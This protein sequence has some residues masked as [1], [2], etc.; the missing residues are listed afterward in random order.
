M[1]ITSKISRLLILGLLLLGLGVSATP[2]LAIDKLPD[3]LKFDNLDLR[4]QDFTNQ[5]LQTAEFAKVKL[6]GSNFRNANLIGVVFNSVTLNEANLQG[7][8]FSQGIAYLTS[9]DNADLSDAILVE[10][11][12][13]RSTFK[14][15]NITGADFSYA[16]LDSEQIDKLCAY[17]SGIN[18]Q[19]GVDTRQSLGCTKK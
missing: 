1:S 11:L 19:T 8:D 9:F 18:S 15:A 13:L 16:V 14:N 6:Q 10:A 2:S 3:N 7:V 4:G 12:L 17:A 5:N